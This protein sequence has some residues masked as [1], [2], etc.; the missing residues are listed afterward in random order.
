MSSRDEE[1]IGRGNF[2]CKRLE[3][4]QKKKKRIEGIENEPKEMN[5]IIQQHLKYELLINQV[6]RLYYIGFEVVEWSEEDLDLQVTQES[7][8]HNSLNNLQYL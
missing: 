7:I 2:Y 6:L 3:N 5:A 4:K 8:S 1:I